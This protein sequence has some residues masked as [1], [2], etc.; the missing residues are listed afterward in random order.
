MPE[1]YCQVGDLAHALGI[2]DVA[3]D[4][5]ME[6]AVEAASRAIDQHCD[7][8]FY[9]VGTE[10]DPA[11]FYFTAGVPRTVRIDD[12]VT[13]D[14]VA[15]DQDGSG[16]F[17]TAVTGFV[18]APYNPQAGWPYTSV[19]LP[20]QASHLFPLHRRGV[21]VTGVFG[22]PSVPA[23]VTEAAVMQSA[24]WLKRVKEAPFGVAGM[25]SF[26]GA[27][28]RLMNRLDPDVELML[29]AL[30]RNPILVG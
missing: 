16:T 19:E 23:Q 6:L 9:Q 11:V 2:G 25:P 27:G 17:A 20:G 15:V 14:E 21:R 1:T 13:I 26:D 12:A 10:V 29:S 22:W 28:I 4:P 8:F 5:E 30:R 7:R 18:A 24:R 3:D